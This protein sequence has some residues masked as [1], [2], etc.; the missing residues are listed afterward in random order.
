MRTER[1]EDPTIAAIVAEMHAQGL[2]RLEL[3]RRLGWGRMQLQRRLAGDAQL[4]VAELQE[5]ADT[6]G[7]DVMQLFRAE[8]AG[9]A[10]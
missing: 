4:T 5:I 7:V 2:S 1:T 10:A 6:L 3:A 8:P 9:G